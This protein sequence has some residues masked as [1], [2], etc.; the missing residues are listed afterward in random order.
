MSKNHFK[1]SLPKTIRNISTIL[2]FFIFSN[3]FYYGN[4]ANTPNHSKEISLE[5][6][7]IEIIAIK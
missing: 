4:M 2:V 7:K 5:K 3:I 6:S 1:L